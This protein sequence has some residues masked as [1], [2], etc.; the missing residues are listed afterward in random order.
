MAHKKLRKNSP[1][2]AGFNGRVASKSS[3]PEENKR[4]KEDFEQ[5]LDDAVLG[6]SGKNKA[7]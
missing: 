2:K 5:L 4:H 7:G 1:R 6:V 3:K